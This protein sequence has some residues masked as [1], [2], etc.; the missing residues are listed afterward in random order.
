MKKF[1]AVAAVLAVTSANAEELKF[2]DLNY[3]LKAGQLNVGADALVHNEYSRIGGTEQ[4]NDAYLFNAHLGYAFNDAFNATVEFGYLFQGETENEGGQTYGTDG[5][6]NPKFAVNYR[7]LDQ[8]KDGGVNFDLGAVATVNV[9]DRE[10]GSTVPA[11]NKDGNMFNFQSSN[12]GDPRNSLEINARIGRKWNEANEF[13]VL[14][15]VV[16]SMDGEFDDLGTDE[17]VDVDGSTD[18][19]LGAFYQYRPVMEFMMTFGVTA[20]RYNDLYVESDTTEAKYRD[21]VDMVFS[22]NAKYLVNDTTI[23]KFVM[24]KDRK[25]KVTEELSNTEIDKRNGDQYGLGV[26]FLF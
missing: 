16:Q 6:L 22:F 11:T 17:T 26:D 20:T 15:G 9:M 23:V 5:I 8:N 14:A 3:F 2:G 21:H 12:L 10:V 7:F 4:E 25:D 18:Y 24:T 13:Y 19:K 1:L